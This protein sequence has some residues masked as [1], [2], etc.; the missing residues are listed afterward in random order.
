[1]S[2]SRGPSAT[3]AGAS[4]SASGSGN[5]PSAGG[6][7]TGTGTRR[8]KI[9]GSIDTYD[10]MN[11]I[12]DKLSILNYESSFLRD[13][14]FKH[15]SR[16]YFAAATSQRDQFPY[17]S[18]LFVWA[19]ERFNDEFVGWDEYEDPNMATHKI[20]AEVTNLGFTTSDPRM[21][22]TPTDILPGAGD[23][24]CNVLDFVLTKL[25]E[26]ERIAFS[27]KPE[28][29]KMKNAHE[30][31]IDDATGAAD[32]DEIEE[33]F[34]TPDDEQLASGTAAG[35]AAGTGIGID[36]SDYAQIEQFD[37][38]R[39]I[40]GVMEATTD[41]IQWRI[42]LERVTPLLKPIRR[43]SSK[44]WRT[45]LEQSSKHHKHMVETFEKC[46][47]A[48]QKISTEMDKTCERIS[49]KERHIGREFDSVATNFRDKQRA[50]QTE[51][52]R[53]NELSE[54]VASL[55]AD[56]ASLTES[57]ELTKAQRED[58]NNSMTD[59]SPIRRI[60][61]ALAAVRKDIAEMELRL[62]VLQATLPQVSASGSRRPQIGRR[63]SSMPSQGDDTDDDI[64]EA[65]LSSDNDS[66]SSNDDDDDDDD[67][68]LTGSDGYDDGDLT[69]DSSDDG[70]ML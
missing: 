14:D 45:H 59:T 40:Q 7:G 37:Q 25:L 46:Q 67:S 31:A 8:R 30:T 61:S 29:P 21:R 6:T 56:L 50:F 23:A 9:F 63:P 15:L 17:F 55:T 12:Y 51:Q 66:G 39:V 42:E 57:V 54:S 28:F 3:S 27:V 53:Y 34:I 32:D 58:R 43:P 1:M 60:S 24:A 44:E 38:E 69:S 26:R 62:G 33:D 70:S 47:A 68:S 10:L 22:L 5:R 64:S 41:P 18:Q 13:N 16:T 36:T 65:D 35:T 11:N 19:M 4:G 49:S 2:S 48:I 52:K 20:I